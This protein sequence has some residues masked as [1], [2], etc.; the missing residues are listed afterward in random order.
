MSGPRPVPAARASGLTRITPQLL[1]VVFYV[2]LTVIMTWPLVAKFQTAVLG[3]PGD[4]LEYVWKMW[5]FRTAMVEPTSSGAFFNQDVFYPFGYP[6]ALSETTVANTVLGMPVT[7]L[8]G[9]TVAYNT[10]VFLSFVVSAVGCF[11]LARELGCGLLPALLSGAAFAYCPYRFSHLGAGH[12]PL[13]GT[14]WIALFFLALE[15]LI[16]N[17]SS[18]RG[19]PAWGRVVALA[20]TY[21]LTALSSWYYA[22]MILLFGVLYLL[23]RARPWR[24]ILCKR[25]L[26]GDL[27]LPVLLAALLISPVALPTFRLYAQGELSHDYS[28]AYVD[29]WSAS[30]VDFLYP[31]A[32][33][34]IWGGPLTER[35]PQNIHENLLYLGVVTMALAAVGLWARWHERP[36]RAFAAIGVIAVVLSLGTTLHHAGRPVYLRVPPAVEHQFSR[37]M[38]VLTGRLA[39]HKVD[40]STLR[41]AGAIVIPMPSLLL[42]LFVPLMSTMRVWTRYG[43]LAMLCVAVAAGWGLEALLDR[44]GQTRDSLSERP[45]PRAGAVRRAAGLLAL[46]LVLVDF[47]V[48][49]YPYGY[50]E[51]RAQPVDRWLAQ[52]PPGSPIIQYPL[53]KTWYGWMLS[54]QRIHRQPIAYGYGTFVPGAYRQASTEVATWPSRASLDRLRSW[55]IRFVL[56]GAKSYGERW[57]VVRE[58]IASLQG[59]RE[60]GVFEDVPTWHADRLLR[61][62]PPSSEVPVTELVSGHL[63]AYLH[64]EIHVYEVE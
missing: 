40:F 4:N 26:W 5:W 59:L 23:V 57:P 20:L 44:L 46:A 9:E 41:R 19:W 55:G 48:L 34:S 25:E 12:L 3:P 33:H 51:V 1:V 10:M 53:G 36:A 38:Y 17:R 63:Q 27:F 58:G 22:L 64:D 8:F 13:M 39:L 29:R 56:V 21:S 60:V 24:E 45:R 31:N 37:A 11:A 30:P 61:R 49:P 54:P 47:A 35:Y 42:Y 2:V 62:V 18:E 16:K 32:M 28:L 50:T 7:V 6:L 14:G 15:R 52:Q 43:I